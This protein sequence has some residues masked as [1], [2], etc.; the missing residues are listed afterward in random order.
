MPHQYGVGVIFSHCMED[1][2]DKPVAYVS[3]S[4]LDHFSRS[5]DHNHTIW[6]ALFTAWKRSF[7]TNIW[8][9]QISAIPNWVTL[10]INDRPQAFNPFI[11][12][13]LGAYQL[14]LGKGATM[15]IDPEWISLLNKI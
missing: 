1:N 11:R 7:D 12:G 5:H 10:H 3:W 13:K 2:S 9:D 14:S 8:C 4:L 6:E 15:G